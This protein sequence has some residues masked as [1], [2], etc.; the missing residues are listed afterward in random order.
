MQIADFVC[1]ETNPE[2]FYEISRQIHLRLGQV[3]VVVNVFALAFHVS[4]GLCHGAVGR[5]KV[6]E[7]EPRIGTTNATTGVV[8]ALQ[9]KRPV[10][11]DKRFVA[12]VGSLE[13]HSIFVFNR[14]GKVLE[15]R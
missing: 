7:V 11:A 3:Y 10:P 2:K 8:N 12:H 4:C 5:T 9:I 6:Y 15:F 14:D 1:L 13:D